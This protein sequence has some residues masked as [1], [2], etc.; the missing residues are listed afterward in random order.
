M[1]GGGAAAAAA[2]KVLA[3]SPYPAWLEARTPPSCPAASL[4]VEPAHIYL[5][6]TLRG[7]SAVS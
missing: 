1:A 5:V 7:V 2:G 3:V 6:Q 4:A